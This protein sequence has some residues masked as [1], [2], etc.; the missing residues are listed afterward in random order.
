M[1]STLHPSQ[2][3]LERHANMRAIKDEQPRI[4]R[5]PP[6]QPAQSLATHSR[7]ASPATQRDRARVLTAARALKPRP[8]VLR[9]SRRQRG[10]GRRGSSAVRTTGALPCGRLPALG[11]VAVKRH[12]TKAADR[13][14]A[15]LC[16]SL[17][18]RLKGAVE[19]VGARAAPRQRAD[20]GADTG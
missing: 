15:G 2:V 16:D 3:A 14:D 1:P 13:R 5:Q 11:A 18:V 20:G 10:A 12:A 19:L 4:S 8:A 9:G 7:H 17:Y 6:R